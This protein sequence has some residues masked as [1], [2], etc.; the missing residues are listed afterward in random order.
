MGRFRSKVKLDMKELKKLKRRLEKIQKTE[1]EFGWLDE[2]KYSRT[3]PARA[4]RGISIATIAHRNEYGG[5]TV[6]NDGRPIYIPSRPYFRQSLNNSSFLSETSHMLMER[7]VSG[8]NYK[9]VLNFMGK[10]LVDNFKKSVARQN[11]KALHE[12]TVNIKGSKTQWVDTG[13]LV[14][15]FSYEVKMQKGG[16][17]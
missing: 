13:Q 7:V 16:I 4:R 6:N 8:G 1:V 9:S 14:K 3:D 17:K 2:S 11:F 15:S 5:Y 10:E 12:K